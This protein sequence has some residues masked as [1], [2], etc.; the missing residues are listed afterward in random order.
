MDST[1]LFSRCKFDNIYIHTIFIYFPVLCI[2]IVFFGLLYT[3][4]FLSVWDTGIYVG[5]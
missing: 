1:L 3:G 2:Y 4:L 5:V